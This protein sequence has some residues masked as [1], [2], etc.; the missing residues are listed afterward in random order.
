MNNIYNKNEKNGFLFTETRNKT[1]TQT[2][3]KPMNRTKRQTKITC[4]IKLNSYTNIKVY[5]IAES[6]ASAHNAAVPASILT[7]F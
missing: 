7:K 5:Q 3:K 4:Q 6:R 1:T 2:R